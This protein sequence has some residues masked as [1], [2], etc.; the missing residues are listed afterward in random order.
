MSGIPVSCAHCGRPIGGTA[1]WMGNFQY[2]EECTRGPTFAQRYFTPVGDGNTYIPYPLSEHD[3]RR[4]VR[5]EVERM[6]TEI[7]GG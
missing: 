4:I 7:A 3:V 1:V 2:H 5:E 6:K